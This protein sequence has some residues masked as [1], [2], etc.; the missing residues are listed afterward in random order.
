[1]KPFPG[2][3]TDY[4]LRNAPLSAISPPGGI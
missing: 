4:V 1:M 2:M 3:M